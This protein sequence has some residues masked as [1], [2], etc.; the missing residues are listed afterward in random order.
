MSICS[1]CGH[2]YQPGDR[3]C[4]QCGRALSDAVV[5][6]TTSVIP[7]VAEEPLAKVLELT[8]D[9]EQA[10]SALPTGSALFLVRRGSDAG[11]RILVDQEQTTVGRHPKSDIFLD[12]VTVS[13]H[14]ASL[15]R[16]GAD[17]TV[18][19]VGSLNGTYVNRTLIEQPMA[20][21]TGDEVQIGKF[22]LVYF[23][24]RQDMN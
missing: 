15:V 12:D 6:D 1:Q 14:H 19:D 10:I 20:L 8:P 22:R 9:E 24:S 4:A 2:E 3:F 18:S 23:A 21:R 17:L 13:R 5:Q 11:A 16:Q 7:V